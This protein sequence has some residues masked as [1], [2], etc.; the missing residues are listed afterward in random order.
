VADRHP[1]EG[2]TETTKTLGC[3]LIVMASHGRRGLGRLVLGSIAN[4]VV[5]HSDIPIL[6]VR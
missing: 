1:A 4:E 3:D 5:T 2:V 6:I